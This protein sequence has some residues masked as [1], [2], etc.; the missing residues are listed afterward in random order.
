[1]VVVSVSGAK[2]EMLKASMGS[3][4]PT[5]VSTSQGQHNSIAN[6]IYIDL[7]ST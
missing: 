1:V 6:D 5:W 7:W 4:Q 3:P 2:I